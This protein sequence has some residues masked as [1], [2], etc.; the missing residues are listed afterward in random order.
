M[1][2]IV[3]I[4]LALLVQVA[5][6]EF[7][8]G[9]F[10]PDAHS[11]GLG[12]AQVSLPAGPWRAYWNPGALGLSEGFQAGLSVAS[13]ETGTTQAYGL[14][15]ERS[16]YGLGACLRRHDLEMTRPDE[17]GDLQERRRLEGTTGHFGFGLDLSGENPNVRLGV[18]T[19]LKFFDE[20]HT[21]ETFLA[22]EGRRRRYEE[23]E[24]WDLLLGALLRVRIPLAEPGPGS[25]DHPPHL[26]LH[27]GGV[28]KNAL[29]QGLQARADLG[30]SSVS[31]RVEA[32]HRFT[33]A[34]LAC[35]WVPF[36]YRGPHPLVQ[37]I[38]S[39]DWEGVLYTDDG[40][41]FLPDTN[42][43]SAYGL[44]LTFAGRLALRMGV[45]DRHNP[46]PLLTSYGAGLA[47][48]G[49]A[50]DYASSELAPQSGLHDGERLYTVS[51]AARF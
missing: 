22:D 31:G 45:E 41:E 30:L 3:F 20:E 19:S 4:I 44:E 15:Y 25:A 43:I 13:Q 42:P 10:P 48:R 16:F 17:D 33:R 28:A 6:A 35:E 34:G 1:R 11:R 49:F 12:S 47:Y 32:H 39:T 24:Y 2:F 14:T 40:D 36:S 26:A 21:H 46:D 5:E 38:A 50:I 29:G 8:I 37:V 23:E 7:L 27:L 51:L 9:N 18:G